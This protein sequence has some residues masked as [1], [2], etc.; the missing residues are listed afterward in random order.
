M[1]YEAHVG[2]DGSV[3]AVVKWRAQ[4]LTENAGSAVVPAWKRGTGRVEL[5]AW[6]TALSK[7][8]GA[9]ASDPVTVAAVADVAPPCT[10]KRKSRLS[11]VFGFAR[12]TSQTADAVPL[13][14]VNSVAAMPSIVLATRAGENASVSS[15]TKR[16]TA[17]VV[18]TLGVKPVNSTR[19]WLTNTRAPSGMLANCAL[20]RVP[21]V[22]SPT[23]AK[24]TTGE[25]SS[26]A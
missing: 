16:A 8:G 23:V 20:T 2:P 19:C 18:G 5:A 15:T 17:P 1:L 7:A 4:L 24:S 6:P 9:G 11:T 13:V 26:G 25:V 3:A 10:Q 22:A 12:S 14:T 21:A